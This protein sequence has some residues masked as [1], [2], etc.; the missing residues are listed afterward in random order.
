MATVY[1]Y[2]LQTPDEFI[3]IIHGF[4][5]GRV[6]ASLTLNDPMVSRRHGFFE[7]NGNKLY[8]TDE[9][10][11]NPTLLNGQALVSGDRTELRMG[12]T[13]QFGSTLVTVKMSM[14]QGHGVSHVNPKAATARS[15]E[16]A[17]APQ[18][19]KAFANVSLKQDS[20]EEAPAP[21]VKKA[22]PRKSSKNKST[23]QLKFQ[24]NKEHLPY[25]LIGTAVILIL[26]VLVI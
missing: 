9:T 1:E 3:P 16:P 18:G 2:H 4:S 25:L 22:K 21:E 12:D 11:T 24:L 6:Q 13:L 5:V 19:N 10:K 7:I 17:A 23:S 8:Y 20:A 14:A 15:Q 26:L